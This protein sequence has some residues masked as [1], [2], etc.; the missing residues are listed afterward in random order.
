[1]DPFGCFEMYPS[2]LRREEIVFS[3]RRVLRVG[4][5]RHGAVVEWHPSLDEIIFR[6]C[7][8][9]TSSVGQLC[10]CQLPR[11]HSAVIGPLVAAELSGVAD[12][13]LS[14]GDERPS[15]DVMATMSAR[16]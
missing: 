16:V 14:S 4:D 13:R 11:K 9:E 7:E 10:R 3:S 15:L 2:K 6:A 12:T 1:M 5:H 8:Q